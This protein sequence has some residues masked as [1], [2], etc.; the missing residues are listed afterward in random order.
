[1]S[2]ENLNTVVGVDGKT[3]VFI[4]TDNPRDVRVRINDAQVWPSPE[5]GTLDDEEVIRLYVHQVV[6]AKS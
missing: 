1:M 2:I 5:V 4:D 6:E 3:V